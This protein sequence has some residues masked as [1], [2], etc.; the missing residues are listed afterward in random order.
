MPLDF[1]SGNVSKPGY[2]CGRQSDDAALPFTRRL[3]TGASAATPM[4]ALPLSAQKKTAEK[5][6]V[7]IPTTTLL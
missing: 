1:A 6:V 7:G 5:P 2:R 4:V 3:I